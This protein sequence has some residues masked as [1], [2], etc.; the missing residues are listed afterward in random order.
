MS[1]WMLFASLSQSHLFLKND[2][3][4]ANTPA[5]RRS[6]ELRL[7]ESSKKFMVY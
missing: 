2:A 3:G 6:Y 4:D 5:G 7:L 1:G